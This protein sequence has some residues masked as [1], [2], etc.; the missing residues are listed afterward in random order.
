MI[1]KSL[2]AIGLIGVVAGPAMAQQPQ[3]QF[4]EVMEI[5][6]EGD[7]QFRHIGDL[8]FT[9][10]GHLVVADSARAWVQVFNKTTGEFVSRFGGKGDEDVSL[11]KPEGVAVDKDGNIYVAD[12]ETGYVK[13]YDKALN[14]VLTFSEYGTGPGQN[15]KS[16]HISIF[17][18]RLYLPEAGSH[19]VDVFDLNGNF[20]FMFG[21][22]GSGTGQL[23]SP[24]AAKANSEGK[25]YVA[26]QKNDRIQV[27]DKDGKFLF[28]FGTSGSLP[29][30]LKAPA[31]IAFDKN[32]N[33]Y[34]NEFGNNRVSIFDKY[35]TY[36]G[37]IID[38]DTSFEH[39]HGIIVDME[40]GWVYVANSGHNRID[41]FKPVS[42]SAS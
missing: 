1:R 12:Y 41:V 7:G 8:A 13:K 17:D 28:S 21:S 6:G 9:S 35:G 37:Q 4:E 22:E 20:Q 16:A 42:G 25:I 30:Q 33:V 26:D 15:S 38:E 19:R 31:G 23:K 2:F 11:E 24:A 3:L 10:E 39:L 29:G 5:G 18:G 34:V 27:F 40:T 14:W 32:G 36:I